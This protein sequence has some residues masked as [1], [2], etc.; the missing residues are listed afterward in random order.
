MRQLSAQAPSRRPVTLSTGPI[1]SAPVL[2]DR[3][4]RRRAIVDCDV[5]HAEIDAL[6]ARE[7]MRE[8]A[9]G[10]FGAMQKAGMIEARA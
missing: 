9:R 4:Y 5:T 1:V 6:V 7:H 2:I 8:L 3:E 10:Y